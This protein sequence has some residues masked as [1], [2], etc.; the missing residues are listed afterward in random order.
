MFRQKK[1]FK[2]RNTDGT[3]MY[4]TGAEYT[5]A[6]GDGS[7]KILYGLVSKMRH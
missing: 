6:G 2:K 5:P 3:I 7:L 4:Q 1:D